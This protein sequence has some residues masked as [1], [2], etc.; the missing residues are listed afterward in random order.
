[1]IAEKFLPPDFLIGDEQDSM[2]AGHEG[3][4]RGD[5]KR[6]KTLHIENVDLVLKIYLD[7]FVLYFRPIS[8]KIVALS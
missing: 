7:D 5:W 8:N 3:V 2:S 1:M 6:K 4:E